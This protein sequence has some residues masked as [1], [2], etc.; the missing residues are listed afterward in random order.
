[1]STTPESDAAWGEVARVAFPKADL[2]HVA[3][4]LDTSHDL[5]AADAVVGADIISSLSLPRATDR[6]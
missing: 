3:L 4:C 6:A 1:V 2:G 5:E